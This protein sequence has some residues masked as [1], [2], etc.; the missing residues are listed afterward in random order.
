MQDNNKNDNNNVK[1]YVKNPNV[2]IRRILNEKKVAKKR[3]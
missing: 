3:K 1:N 2:E